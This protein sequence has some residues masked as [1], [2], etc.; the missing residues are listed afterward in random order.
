MRFTT[1][2][3]CVASLAG[4]AMPALADHGGYSGAL[5]TILTQTAAGSCAAELMAP[6]LLSAC[7]EQLPRLKASLAGLGP[8]RSIAFVN[9]AKHKGKRVETYKVTFA[10]GD[11]VTWH[12]GDLN[13]GKY[14]SVYS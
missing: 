5:R 12:I 11:T 10:K 6:R 2:M 7:Q 8:I 1:S 3:I 4:I 9:A 14:E 13:G